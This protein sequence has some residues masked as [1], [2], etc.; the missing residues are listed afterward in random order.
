MDE[1][2]VVGVIVV[3][4]GLIVSIVTP[5]IKLNTSITKLSC[6]VES[7]K[8]YLDKND[9]CHV[10]Y[11]DKLADHETRLQIIEKTSKGVD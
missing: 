11:T 9:Q 5:L 3:L 8:Q 1:W 7:M 2:T 4:F 10:L 6:A